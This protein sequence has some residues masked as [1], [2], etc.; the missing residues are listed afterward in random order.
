MTADTKGIL[1]RFLQEVWTNGD[2]EAAD[3]YVAPFYT[4]HHDPS[5]PWDGQTLDLEG[6][7]DRV[8]KS[9]YPFPDQSFTVNELIAEPGKVVTT[10]FW[11]GTHKE[12]IPGFPASNKVI[13]MSGM[14]VYYFD[15]GRLTG[16]WQLTDRLGVFQQL[17]Q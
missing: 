13:S 12:D 3:E 17:S 7:K 6:F 14:T 2:V 9:R 16:H 11:K 10:W 1:T 8:R 4:I 5:D 15:G